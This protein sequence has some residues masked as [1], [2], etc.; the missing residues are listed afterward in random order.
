[1]LALTVVWA[2][3]PTTALAQDNLAVAAEIA[4]LRQELQ[5]QRDMIAAQAKTI[6]LQQARLDALQAESDGVLAGLRGAGLRQ[7]V[8]DSEQAPDRP[9]G[10]APPEPEIA[11]EVQAIPQEQG[12]LTPAGR[13]VLETAVE[14]TRSSTNRLVFRGFELI[15]GI[16]IGLIEA[17]DADRDTVV[18]TGSFRYGLSPRLEIDG[19]VPYVYRNDRIEVVQ[20]RDD[21]IVRSIH[22]DE[23]GIGDIELGL[24]YQL[25]QVRPLRPTWVA[26]L[27]A[28]SDT[29]VG[30]FDV[31]YDEFGVARGLAT[32]SGFWAVQPGLSL[33]LPSDPVVLYGGASY[34]YQIPR[35][36]N[37]TIG[38][39]F[40]GNVDP[41]DAITGNVGFGFALN[42]RFSYSLGYRH[43]YIFPTRTEIGTTV[44]KSNPL[45][46]G[47]LLLGMSYRVTASQVVNLGFEFGVTE[48]A[49]DVSISLRLPITAN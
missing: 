19:R 24:R 37:R 32:G 25:N 15:P 46:I 1:L 9:V 35:D 30:P 8:L 41:G 14:Y 13:L 47:S 21:S 34:I 48:D 27:R 10:V 3:S 42:P 5:S 29:G 23:H 6:E 4:A 17:T 20:Q 2:A 31:D 22:L 38:G 12:V 16:Q 33:L 49:P 7:A 18:A 36:V 26:S 44:Q 39:A 40:V 43:H 45:Q 11:V 28:K